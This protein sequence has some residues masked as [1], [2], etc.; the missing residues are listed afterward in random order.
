M[1]NLVRI[2]RKARDPSSQEYKEAIKEF[3]E[4][5]GGIDKVQPV[6]LV[7]CCTRATFDLLFPT[8]IIK[9]PIETEVK[10]G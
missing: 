6:L 4:K 5:M 10:D 2:S 3:V 7:T 8:P 1:A 9:V